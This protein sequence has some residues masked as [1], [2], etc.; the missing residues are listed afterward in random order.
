MHLC[1]LY[2][3]TLGVK[4][5][6]PTFIPHY[7]PILE[8]DF[9][10]F[11]NSSKSPAKEYSWWEDVLRIVKPELH[12]RNIKI[13]QIGAAEDKKVEG[14]DEFINTTTL[15]QSSFFLKNCLLHLGIDSCP[16]HIASHFD[17]PTVTLYA[18]NFASVCQPLWNGNKAT[19]IESHRNGKKPSFSANEDPKMIDLI[20]PEEV[21]QA[22]FDQLGLEQTT[23]QK[24]LY[25]G[26]KYLSK[27][28]DV[29][30]TQ[31]CEPIN[32]DCNIRVRLDMAINEHNLV[33]FLANQ[34][35][36]VELILVQ[37]FKT[38]IF[39]HFK[40]KIS[41]I[42]YYA[43]E[44]DEKFLK[45][46]K[47]SAIPFELNCMSK[48]SLSEQRNKFFNFDIV[49]ENPVEDAQKL[50]E[51]N[52]QKIQGNPN[53]YSGKLYQIGGEKLMTL[54]K[55][56]QDLNFWLDAPWFRVYNVVK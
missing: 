1:G 49:Y 38:E 33:Q 11:H 46:L 55:N 27:T 30:L 6:Y 20:M 51:E 2:G 12:K 25:I 26:K 16:A 17:K 44:F 40:S 8:N 48:E 31:P 42:I 32:I 21:A 35:R 47:H 50:K 36:Q 5:G 45:Y 34:P 52:I 23:N 39:D 4:V 54:G 19:L 18:S 13:I 29:I 15:K 43:N 22:V 14:V 24:T 7:Y 28:I 9:I 41:K 53:F 10:V 3:K 37:P 56:A